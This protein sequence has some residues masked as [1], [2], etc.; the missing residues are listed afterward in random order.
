MTIRLILLF[1]L[2]HLLS[3]F[4]AEIIHREGLLLARFNNLPH[5]S[6]GML[7]Y[8]HIKHPQRADFTRDYLD[9]YFRFTNDEWLL[10]GQRKPVVSM[11]VIDQAAEFPRDKDLQGLKRA[12]MKR[13]KKKME[14]NAIP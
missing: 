14:E 2:L 11:H 8:S 5:R 6:L 13:H 12:I 4:H 3:V 1:C 10:E 9:Q 7:Y